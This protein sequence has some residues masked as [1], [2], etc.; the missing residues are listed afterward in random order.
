MKFRWFFL[1]TIAYFLL[2]MV[3]ILFAFSAIFCMTFPFILLSRTGKKTWCAAICPRSHFLTKL[4]F[5]NIGIRSPRWLTGENM[6]RNMLYYFGINLFFIAM[7]TLMVSIG[8]IAPIDKIRL[9]IVFQLPIGLP[10]LIPFLTLP[11][12]LI[13]LGYRFYSLMLT[14]TLIG[15]GL[16]VLFKPRTWCAICPVNTLSTSLLGKINPNPDKENHEKTI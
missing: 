13:H 14:S 12:P 7:S 8:R 5:L 6:R 16:A 1:L 11:A 15:I 2:P 10:Q 3:N 9:L 4:K